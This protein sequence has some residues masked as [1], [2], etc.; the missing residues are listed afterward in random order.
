MEDAHNPE[1]EVDSSDDEAAPLVAENPSHIMR[2]GQAVTVSDRKWELV[3]PTAISK[4]VREAAGYAR[5]K[6]SLNCGGKDTSRLELLFYHVLPDRWVD[7]IL[8]YTNVCLSGL[9]KEDA[10][11]TKGELLKFFGYM[12]FL[13]LHDIHSLDKMWGQKQDPQSTA[14]P[15][16]MGRFGL[17]ITRFNLLRRT[18]R[19]G[20][21]D[22]ASFER[23]KWCTVRGLVDS[24]NDHMFDAFTPGWLLTVDES[25]IAWRGQVG[26]KN[27]HHCPHRMFV[28]RKPEPLGVELKDTGDALSGMLLF[29][30]ITEG[31]TSKGTWTP[32]HWAKQ[33]RN[34]GTSWSA[35]TATTLRLVEK[36]AGTG[37]VVAG[38]AWFASINTCKA[39]MEHGLYFIGD[40]KTNHAQYPVEHVNAS[41]GRQNGDR[42]TFMADLKLG[43]S[44]ETVPIYCVGHRRGLDCSEKKSVHKF[45]AT[46]GTTLPGSN[47]TAY[48]EDDREKAMGI[49]QDFEIARKAP[50]VINDF[51]EGQP[52]IDRH[53]RYRQAILALEKRFVTNNFSFRFFTSMLGILVTNAYFAHRY[54]N[55]P[56]ADFKAEIDRLAMRLI[57]NAFLEP[58]EVPRTPRTGFNL[59]VEVQPCQHQLL[60][61]KCM[62]GYKDACPGS[63]QQRC[64]LCNRFTSWYCG[65]CST[66]LMQLLPICPEVTQGRNGKKGETFH[67]ACFREHIQNPESRYHLKLGKKKRGRK[68]AQSVSFV[69]EHSPPSL[70]TTTTSTSTPPSSAS[71]N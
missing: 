63:K 47:H 6:P 53:N 36:W 56:I 35:T 67:H 61:L 2:A 13:A 1:E 71:S 26:Q 33:P 41:T 15:G 5:N 55:D 24:F 8:K 4:D 46:C 43:S 18:L 39:L 48:F 23:D 57:N 21:E 12:L 49:I 28:K 66:Q 40:V 52:C 59:L 22:D 14:P 50:K 16:N 38:D 70:N 68:S 42:S 10:K 51:S 9:T 58:T 69:C 62:P 44:S 19:F 11:L 54:F 37:R 7:D 17:S 34:T 31:S 60:P 64:A 27:R 45:V 29:L 30:E 32:R 3:Q 25:M 65:A 20:P